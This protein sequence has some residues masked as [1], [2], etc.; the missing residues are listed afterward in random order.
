GLWSPSKS[1]RTR[2]C[3][4]VDGTDTVEVTTK[5]M[6]PGP[7]LELWRTLRVLALVLAV[8][9]SSLPSTSISAASTERNP[10]TPMTKGVIAKVKLPGPVL[11]LRRT[12]TLLVCIPAT[13][14][15]VLPSPSRSAA[16]TQKGALVPKGRLTMGWAEKVGVAPGADV[17]FCRTVM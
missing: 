11:V 10:P 17:V 9:R 4:L 15:S 2:A 1:A 13:A 12:V 16:I 8:T 7:V 14:R 5:L 6:L 3:G